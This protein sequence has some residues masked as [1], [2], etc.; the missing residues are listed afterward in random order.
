MPNGLTHQNL[1]KAGWI[2]ST[3][4][5][6]YLMTKNPVFGVGSLIG[7]SAGK[8]I[9]PD[10]DIAGL[11]H[12]EGMIINDFKV[13][14]YLIVGYTTVYGITFRRH[15][16]SF[17]THF[18]WV[19]TLG[20]MIFLFWWVPI[21]FSHYGIIFEWW[22]FDLALGFW[23]GLGMSDLVHYTADMTIGD[24]HMSKAILREIRRHSDN[25]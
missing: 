8:Y 10:W 14:G 13:L 9:T 11:T 23:F 19:S 2:V 16:R 12:D 21:A 24:K 7:Y 3:P 20:R 4:A 1:W 22:Q 15:H 18:P 25:F 5:S 17:W 6:L